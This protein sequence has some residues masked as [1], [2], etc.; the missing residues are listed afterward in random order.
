MAGDN[1]GN[2]WR[3]DCRPRAAA[4]W[5]VAK[6][7]TLTDAYRQSAADHFGARADP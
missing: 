1:L 3:F 7:A 5:S 2:V 4:S 6:L